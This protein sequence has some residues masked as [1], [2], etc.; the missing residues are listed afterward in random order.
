M[1]LRAFKYLLLPPALNVLLILAA[2]L[3]MKPWPRLRAMTLASSV[4]SLWLFSTPLVAVS[5]A[6]LLQNRYPPLTDEQLQQPAFEAIVVLGAG[7]DYRGEE[8]QALTDSRDTA[9]HT[10][11]SFALQRLRYAS[12]LAAKTDKPLLLSGGHVYGE[13]QAEAELMQQALQHWQQ[14]A[15]WLETNSRTTAENALFSAKKLQA[16]G[17][18]HIAL[19]THGWHMPRALPVFQRQGLQV[20][21][22]PTAFYAMPDNT[23]LALLPKS[24]YLDISSRMLHELLGQLWYSLHYH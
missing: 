12:A 11:N 14:Q 15:R 5:L 20:T 9:G 1:L 4:I 16:E 6:D 22:A 8:W 3:L 18:Q 23:L 7:R 17:I 24:Y 21:P 10:V 19:V 13:A 2:W